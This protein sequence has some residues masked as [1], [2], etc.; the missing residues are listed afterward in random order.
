MVFH[1][2][3]SFASRKVEVIHF[4]CSGLGTQLSSRCISGCGGAQDP[5]DQSTGSKFGIL[6]SNQLTY[7]SVLAIYLAVD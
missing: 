3:S 1:V 6:C 4:I 7:Y 2:N 5:S